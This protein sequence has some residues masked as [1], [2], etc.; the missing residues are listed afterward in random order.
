MRFVDAA[1][2]TVWKPHWLV[3][4]DSNRRTRLRIRC[5]VR[6]SPDQPATFDVECRDWPRGETLRTGPHLRFFPDGSARI[7]D[8]T[9][10]WEQVAV[11]SLGEWVRIEFEFEQGDGAPKT[12]ALRLSGPETGTVVREALPFRSREFRHCTW[13]GF[14]G[15]DEKTAV[16]YADDVVIE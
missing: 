8:D 3:S 11:F 12:Y 1:G 5:S 7:P 14:A 13:F 2:V 16:F 4:F 9:G 6:N 10:G 15:M